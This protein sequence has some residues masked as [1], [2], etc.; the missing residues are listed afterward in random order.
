LDEDSDDIMY[1]NH[2]LSMKTYDFPFGMNLINSLT[3]GKYVPFFPTFED[4]ESVTCPCSRSRDVD[5]D[6][7]RISVN[8]N[9]KAVKD[10]EEVDEF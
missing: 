8:S 10:K 3:W 4:F 1:N 6:L 5:F 9:D 7:E 2:N